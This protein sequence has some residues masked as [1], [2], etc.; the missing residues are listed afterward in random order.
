MCVNGAGKTEEDVN[1]QE[2][3]SINLRKQRVVNKISFCSR[4]ERNKVLGNIFY[5]YILLVTKQYRLFSF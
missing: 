3:F 2:M 4:D 1:V 5:F